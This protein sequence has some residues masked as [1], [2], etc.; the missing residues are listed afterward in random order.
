MYGPY[1]R[2]ARSAS[3]IAKERKALDEPPERGTQLLNELVP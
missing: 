2:D 3:P 1:K